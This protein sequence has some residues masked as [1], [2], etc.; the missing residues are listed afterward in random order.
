MYI[1][2]ERMRKTLGNYY[3]KVICEMGW[4]YKVYY[5]Q[6]FVFGSCLISWDTF[7]CNLGCYDSSFGLSVKLWERFLSCWS[8]FKTGTLV[9]PSLNDMSEYKWMCL[10]CFLL[11]LDL[12]ELKIPGKEILLNKMFLLLLSRVVFSFHLEEDTGQRKGTEHSSFLPHKREW[13]FILKQRSF[14]GKECP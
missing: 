3:Y 6:A 14:A 8:L 2:I 4:G 1:F 12:T 9:R 13:S 7:F 11:A 10:I 5:C